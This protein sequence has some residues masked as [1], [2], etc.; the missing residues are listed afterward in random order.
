MKLFYCKIVKNNKVPIKDEKFSDAK[1]LRKLSEIDLRLYNVGLPCGP[2][3]LIVL[4][5]DVKDDG[6]VEWNN[7]ISEFGEP[8]TVYE[9]TPSGGYH[10]YFLHH[11]ANYTF[12]EIELINKLKNKSKYRNKGLDIRI[13]NGGYIVCD[14]STIDGKKYEYIRK[15][16]TTPILEMPLTLLNWLLE[17]EN[18]ESIINDNILVLLKNTEKLENILSF[19]DADDSKV[20]HKVTACIK[21]LLHPYNSLEKEKFLEIWDDWSKNSVKYD[22]INNNKIWDNIRLN[23]NMNYFIN[24]LI[25]NGNDQIK[26][27]ETI[28]HYEPLI[29]EL[30]STQIIN[31][32][33]KYIYD[34]E[35][36]GE[37]FDLN[38]FTK[39]DTVIIE[40]TTG[41]G[42]T[43]NTAKIINQYI[44][45]NHCV[46][47]GKYD[48]YKKYKILS[49]ISRKS[50]ASQHI[51]SFNKEEI[52][53]VSYLEYDKDIEDDNIVVCVNSLSMFSK[54]KPEFFNDY[55]VYIDEVATFTRHFT[56]NSTLD[57]NLKPI[58]I[59][60]M[61]IINNCMKLIMT[62][63]MIND[64]VFSL[65][66][67]RKIQNKVFIKN[68]F[69]KYDG[70]SAI[71]HNDEEKFLEFVVSKVKDKEYFLFGCD[72]NIKIT[73][74]YTE[75]IKHNKDDCILITA[76]IKY[77]LENVS[78]QFKNKFVF[79]SPSITCGVDFNIDE[80][81]DAI[82]YINGL[83]LKP[84]DSFQ[85]LTRTRNIKKAYFY[86]NEQKKNKEP[87]YIDI[88]DC[89]EKVKGLSFTN[90]ALSNFC[91]SLNENDELVFNEN[92]FFDLFVYNEYIEDIYETNKELHF[93]Q[94]LK[95]NG[96]IVSSVNN[97]N[98]LLRKT[99]GE[100]KTSLENYKE[101]KFNDHIE[102]TINDEILGEKMKF[103]NLTNKDDKIEYYDIINNKIDYE[104][105]MNLMRFFSDDETIKEKIAIAKDK[106]VEYKTLYYIYNKIS[107]IKEFE[108]AIK[109]ESLEVNKIAINKP[110]ILPYEL[111]NKINTAFRSV[112]NPKTFNEC[113]D[114]YVHKL[115]NIFGKLDIIVSEKKQVNKIRSMHYTIDNEKLKRYFDLH[116]I[117]N[118]TR[119][120]MDKNL[121]NR[122]DIPIKTY[123]YEYNADDYE[124]DD[125]YDARKKKE[126]DDL[127]KL[128]ALTL[129]YEDS[130][131]DE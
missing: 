66:K 111:I 84:C 47:E 11:S 29:N 71:Q 89:K 3:N 36:K 123:N 125:V 98:K 68:S 69:K 114:Y 73:E 19:L 31:M 46:K 13:N 14:P 33:N 44:T 93:K 129:Y 54:Y 24:I 45:Q 5:I 58:Y 9:K 60:L 37:Q 116:F 122:L 91:V 77:D 49:I 87:K 74:Y 15:M 18:Q 79:Y 103:L 115:K 70:I 107:L 92:S 119:N 65:I 43:S 25:K 80:A 53:L 57:G 6:I 110:I 94:I 121:L 32:Q 100:L 128:K 118:P 38:V 27:F 86:I 96:F 113:I 48:V 109:I 26:Y 78:E 117:R 52:K 22:R 40:S 8:L 88:H 131:D 39:Y 102:G 85:Q 20:W 30:N 99:K 97:K 82:L 10:Y 41:T 108:K 2:N 42:K 81:Q 35:F 16:D 130:E 124:D 7:Y 59:T 61:K 127:E 28:K 120:N 75:C 112:A 63:A 64:N 76:D 50:L 21:N 51:D 55:I 101:K 23:I 126:K 12:E 72:S 95:N 34:E 56:H 106:N 17:Y 4:D 104:A 83:T 105:Y 67:K 62:E 90:T 1:K